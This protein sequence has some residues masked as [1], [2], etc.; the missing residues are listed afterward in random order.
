MANVR[1]L[2][3]DTLGYGTQEIADADVLR[4]GNITPAS[5]NLTIGGRVVQPV[6]YA[7]NTDVLVVELGPYTVRA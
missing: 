7:R 6:G 4:I 1:A 2:T 3:R 5:G